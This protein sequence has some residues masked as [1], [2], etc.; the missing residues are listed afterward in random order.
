M[1]LGFVSFA[2]GMQKNSAY[3]DIIDKFSLEAK[4]FGL[5]AY[6][7]RFNKNKSVDETCAKDENEPM[8]LKLEDFQWWFYLFSMLLTI[9]CSVL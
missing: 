8:V 1:N 2:G 7:K 3:I 4:E 6:W 5:M 9:C